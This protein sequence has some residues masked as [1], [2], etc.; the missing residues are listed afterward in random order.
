[1]GRWLIALGVLLVVFGL[2]WPWLGKIGLGRLP[3]DIVIE[4]GGF[5]FYFPIA[6][7]L[8]ISAILSV[9]LWLLNR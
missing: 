6:T 8:L 1:M 4:R 3:G 9:I 7:C 5:H 2:L